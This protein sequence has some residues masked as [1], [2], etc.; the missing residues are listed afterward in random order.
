MTKNEQFVL[1]LIQKTLSRQ[2]TWFH[3]DNYFAMPESENPS[4]FSLVSRLDVF[5][6]LGR[7][8]YSSHNEKFVFI[9]FYCDGIQ[10]FLQRNSDSRLLQIKDVDRSSLYRLYNAVQSC[11]KTD[12]EELDELTDSFFS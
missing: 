10:V 9:F 2:L 6:N 3:A 8:Y 4:L 11:E 7:C 1:T 12:S 5:E